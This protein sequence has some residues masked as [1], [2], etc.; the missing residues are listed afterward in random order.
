MDRRGS[1]GRRLCVA[2][3]AVVLSAAPLAA[4]AAPPV[5]LADPGR[6]SAIELT[7]SSTYL[8]GIGST[9]SAD[10][11]VCFVF[12]NHGAHTATKVGLSLA[13]VDATGT[14]A[15][16]DVMYPTGKFFSG[17]RSA[18]SG[19]RDTVAVPNGNCHLLLT[20]RSVAGSTI[21]YRVG[22]RNASTNIIAIVVSAREIVYDDGTVW[23]NANVPQ[24]GER[25]VLPSALQS[26][27]AVANGP[28]VV[29][30]GNV[31]GSP[32][33]V[34]DAFRYE[35]VDSVRSGN[36]V[37]VARVRGGVCAIFTNHD[38][39]TVKRVSFD[40]S[41]ADRK[42]AIEDVRLIDARG[43]F[44]TGVPIDN[45]NGS[46]RSPGEANCT[47][48]PGVFDAD[49]FMMKPHGPTSAAIAV[50]R[51]VVTPSRVEFT[52]GTAWVAPSPPKVG[53][54]IVRP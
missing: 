15:G 18:F 19:S 23:R 1:L 32:V 33:E 4:I 29:T 14:V 52:D 35:S 43:K 41:V 44:S 8:L 37:N 51:I 28:P 42:G 36:S 34:T 20:P 38:L 50:G 13:M 25:V 46:R 10:N 48:V 17:A 2:A 24:T 31:S 54:P 30:P 11:V 39:R 27:A 22:Q 12:V 45:A 9:G 47:A 16:V 6:P 40:V 5:I 21:S 49:S 3:T 7:E 26:A 53:D